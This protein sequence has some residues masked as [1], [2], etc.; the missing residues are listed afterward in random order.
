MNNSNGVIARAC[1]FA[2]AAAGLCVPAAFA[3]QRP[4]KSALPDFSTK[5]VLDSGYANS[6][7][8]TTAGTRRTFRLEGNKCYLESKFDASDKLGAS[9]QVWRISATSY[10]RAK[11]DEQFCEVGKQVVV[12]VH[13]TAQKSQAGG[14]SLAAEFSWKEFA[15][16][17]EV[18]AL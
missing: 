5:Y 16:K 12:Q 8:L 2:A 3:Q 1:L 18:P 9:G 14:S 15:G 4:A 10:A 11:A 13:K 17:F 7:I 6:V